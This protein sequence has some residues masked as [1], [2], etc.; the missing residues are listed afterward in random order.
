MPFGSL[1]NSYGNVNQGKGVPI[2]QFVAD[3]KQL[4]AL[5]KEFVKEQYEMVENK[6]STDDDKLK[7]EAFGGDDDEGGLFN[8][9]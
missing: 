8:S 1:M 3:A 2:N 7:K 4:F 5:S 9:L 6:K